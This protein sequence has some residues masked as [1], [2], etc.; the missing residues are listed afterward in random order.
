M[1]AA[2]RGWARTLTL[3]LTLTRTQIRTRTLTRW[4]RAL[5]RAELHAAQVGNVADATHTRPLHACAGRSRGQSAPHIFSLP[6]Q[7]PFPY[8]GMR[9][10]PLQPLQLASTATLPC[11]LYDLPTLLPTLGMRDFNGTEAR[12]SWVGRPASAARPSAAL[13]PYPINSGVMV[14]SPLGEAS[15]NPN[16]Y[17]YPYPYPYPNLNLNP[18]PSPHP[19]PSLTLTTLTLPT[20]TLPTLTLTLTSRRGCVAR[21]YDGDEADITWVPARPTRLIGRGGPTLRAA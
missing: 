12:E 9:D 8:L 18:D 7:P 5:P 20:L 6:P 4:P 15:P 14:V 13:C 1:L 3:I 16:P 19:S 11:L 2:A 21:A 17:P 10:L